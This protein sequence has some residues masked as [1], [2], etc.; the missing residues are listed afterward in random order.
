MCGANY[1]KNFQL[2]QG[3]NDTDEKAI[4]RIL[5]DGVTETGSHLHFVAFAN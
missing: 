2:N 1:M 4:K 3:N 5:G